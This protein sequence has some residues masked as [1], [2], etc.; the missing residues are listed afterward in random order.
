[1]PPY[2]QPA[3]AGEAGRETSAGAA[4]ALGQR[5]VPPLAPS[6]LSAVHAANDRI[7]HDGNAV[8]HASNDRAAEDYET[9]TS[10]MGFEPEAAAAALARSGGQLQPALELLVTEGEGGVT[11]SAAVAASAPLSGEGHVE[12]FI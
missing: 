7:V 12:G 2:V 4:A 8:V 11:T 3:F 6:H 10:G 5:A 9:L 1:M